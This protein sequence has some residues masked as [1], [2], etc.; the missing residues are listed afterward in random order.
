M[1]ETIARNPNWI[2]VQAGNETVM[3]NVNSGDYVG[4][5]ETGSAI[6]DLIEVPRELDAICEALQDMF[7]VS[8]EICRAQVER[9]VASMQERGTVMIPEAQSHEG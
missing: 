8:A 1:S 9:F 7:D 6:W 4:L 5:T 3:M 2:S